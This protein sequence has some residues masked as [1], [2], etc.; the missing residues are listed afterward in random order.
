MPHPPAEGRLREVKVRRHLREGLT[1]SSTN[2][3][4]P[5]WSEDLQRR[6]G[7]LFH[8]DSGGLMQPRVLR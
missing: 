1:Y 8:P 5:A 6:L 4:T 7:C 2:F 3:T